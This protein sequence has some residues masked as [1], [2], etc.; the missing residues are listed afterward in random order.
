MSSIKEVNTKPQIISINFTFPSINKMLNMKV[1]QR[2]TLKSWRP[3][4]ASKFGSDFAH[5]KLKFI[6]CTPQKEILDPETPIYQLGYFNKN[7]EVY[8]LEIDI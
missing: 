5:M 4:L 2:S 3:M 8:K 1:N 6:A 7:L